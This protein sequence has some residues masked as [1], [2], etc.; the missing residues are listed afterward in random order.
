MLGG[1]TT[2]SSAGLPTVPNR[3][4]GNPQINGPS[5][6]FLG[7]NVEFT[8]N[9]EDPDDDDIYYFI[10]WNDGSDEIEIGPY[11]SS[12]EIIKGHIWE[13]KGNYQIKV[14]AKDEYGLESDF[15]IY[16]FYIFKSKKLSFV[17][18]LEFDMFPKDACIFCSRCF[19]SS[20]L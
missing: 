2:W 19:H 12:E 1:I 7:E 9:S 11:N 20:F 8:I 14:K 18:F 13:S 3:Q 10:N 6:G 4:P 15:C 16:E 17:L 5:N